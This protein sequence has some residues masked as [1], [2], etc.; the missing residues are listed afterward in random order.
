MVQRAVFDNALAQRAARAGADLRDGVAV[1]S[2]EAGRDGVM[3]QG[4]TAGG[5]S[6]FVAT[7][8]HV[9]G[10]DGANGVTAKAANLRRNRLLAIGMEVEHPHTWG[11]GHP[12]LRSDVVHLEYG[13]IPRGYAWV[14]P[15]GDHLN[16]GAGVFRPRSDGRGD[17]QVRGLLQQAIADYLTMLQVPFDSAA[18][19]FHA[20]P[21]PL[22]N[23]KEPLHTRD[24][25]ILL[26]GDAAGLI[27]PLFGDGIL[28]AVKSGQIA[29]QCL[30]DGAAKEYTRRIHA[31]FAANF[32]AALRIARF[33]YQFT[34]IAYKYGVKREGATRAATR[35]LC[36]D[37]L[38]TD[39]AK[40]TLR[41]LRAAMAKE[42]RR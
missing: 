11:E 32:D 28:H 18:A 7:A 4:Q 15:K 2:I 38:F 12:D 34:G 40:R 31:T 6:A 24:G 39:A 8:R 13:A 20:H 5:D 27:N 3:V 23:G 35:L 1:R 42:S 22:W 29:A 21:L 41:V 26:A 33:F 19:S 16:V 30:A 36:G 37:A 14:F 10:A 9:I 25:R 17:N